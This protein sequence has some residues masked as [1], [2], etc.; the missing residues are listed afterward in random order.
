M[1]KLFIA[2]LFLA[3]VFGACG[4]DV[5]YRN[6]ATIQ[7]NAPVVSLLPGE[8]IEYNVYLWDMALGDPTLQPVSS[9]MFV[10]R[11]SALELAIDMTVIQRKEYAVAVQSVLVQA[12]LAEVEGDVAYST[13]TAD[14]DPTLHPQG[15]FTYAPLFGVIP[16]PTD[17]RD[18]GM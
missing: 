8:S 15:H 12:D 14:V 16:S 10:G 5:I 17:L 13:V 7:W 4:Q 2:V 1:K 3:V 6:T 11:V 18:A 9:L